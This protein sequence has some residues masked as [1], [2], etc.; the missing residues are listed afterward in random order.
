[1][2]N[3]YAFINRHD[4]RE[5]QAIFEAELQRKKVRQAKIDNYFTENLCVGNAVVFKALALSENGLILKDDIACDYWVASFD[6]KSTF[7]LLALKRCL[8]LESA[9]ALFFALSEESP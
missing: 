9:K 6:K 2:S 5:A 3:F 1:M 7:R 8:S 4:Y